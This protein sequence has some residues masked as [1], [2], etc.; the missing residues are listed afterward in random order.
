MIPCEHRLLFLAVMASAACAIGAPNIIPDVKLDVPTDF[1][2]SL[3]VQHFRKGEDV[4]HIDWMPTPAQAA[5]TRYK[6]Y[7]YPGGGP[8]DTKHGWMIDV[9]ST[10]SQ[11]VATA[12]A[13][14]GNGYAAD[15]DEVMDFLTNPR[16]RSLFESPRTARPY[17][18]ARFER[19]SF[20]WGRGVSFFSQD[21]Q[22]TSMPEPANGRLDYE[23]FGVTEDGGFTVVARL[24]VTHPNLPDDAN[25]RDMRDSIQRG[26]SD[27]S[28]AYFDAARQKNYQRLEKLEK[29]EEQKEAA[30]MKDQPGIKLIE[31][32]MP[33][34]FIPSLTAFDKMVDSIKIR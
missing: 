23:I 11:K 2:R 19:K 20:R 33:D 6:G 7:W 1:A 27:F 34:A 18:F 10:H 32:A 17:L 12:Y 21:V 26:D 24:S 3:S 31:H 28:Q 25:A 16:A 13:N 15:L 22:D 30:A 14:A 5:M 29:D 4:L 8:A 9:F